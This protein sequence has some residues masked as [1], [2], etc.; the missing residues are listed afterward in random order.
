MPIA[1]GTS[2]TGANRGNQTNVER[3]SRYHRGRDGRH[4]RNRV[5]FHPVPVV[6]AS[7]CAGAHVSGKSFFSDDDG[8]TW[9]VD[10]ASKIPPFDHEGKVAYRA[11]V[12]KCADGTQFVGRLEK[13]SDEVKAQM[14]E[15]IRKNPSAAPVLQYTASMRE[16]QVKLPGDPNWTKL[17]GSSPS[18][19]KKMMQPTCK[20]GSGATQVRPE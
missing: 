4:H 9:F 2:I 12:F 20:D 13:F 17:V 3:E 1:E 14:E 15:T 16:I 19:L 5:D 6:R 18:V 10:D 8:K 11:A 7:S